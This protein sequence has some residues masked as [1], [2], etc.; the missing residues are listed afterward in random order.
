MV[1]N[2]SCAISAGPDAVSLASAQ[3]KDLLTLADVL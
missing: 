3:T 2:L 1:S